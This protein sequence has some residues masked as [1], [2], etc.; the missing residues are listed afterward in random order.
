MSKVLIFGSTGM[1]GQGVLLECIRDSNVTEIVAIGRSPAPISSP[2]VRDIVHHD[3]SEFKSLAGELFDFDACFFCLGIA[4]AG[5]NEADYTRITHDI[6][7]A[8]AEVLIETSPRLT[9]VFVSGQG[10]ARDSRTMWARVKART[11]DDLMKM[12]FKDVYVIRP[13][14][15]R[16]LDGIRSRTKL[17]NFV[18]TFVAPIAPWLE[19]AFP[20]AIVNTRIVG[21]TMLD[22]MRRGAPSKILHNSDMRTLAVREG[23]T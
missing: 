6:A 15:I 13:A 1:I 3:M 7:L 16:P 17:Y 18:Y 19:R 21:R 10:A 2:K 14:G 12:P 22:L 20:R 5:M 8:A 9:F 4:S 11:E 23:W